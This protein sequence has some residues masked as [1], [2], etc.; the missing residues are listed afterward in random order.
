VYFRE[1]RFGEVRIL[2]FLRTS[3]LSDSRKFG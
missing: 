2:G 1:R 3:P